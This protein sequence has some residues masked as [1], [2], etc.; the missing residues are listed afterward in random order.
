[1][2][3]GGLAPRDGGKDMTSRTLEGKN[4]FAGISRMAKSITMK[5]AA[6]F[7]PEKVIRSV[8]SNIKVGCI[9]VE[10]PDSGKWTLGH[11]ESSP[12][13]RVRVHRK[14]LFENLVQ[15]WDVGLGESYQLGDYDVDDLVA[16]IS[17]I[18]LNIPHL[19]GISGS[20]ALHSEVNREGGENLKIHRRNG[21]TLRGS[22]TNIAYHYD[23]SNGLYSLFLDPT[24]AYSCAVYEK[25]EDSL[26]RA[27]LNKFERLCR[28]LELKPGDHVL[29]IG[30]GWGGF[31]IY[32][33]GKYGCKVTTLT[34][35][36]EQKALA[37]ERIHVA[38]LESRIEVRLQDY[39]E[40]SGT[41]D[42]I[43][44]IE[45][46]EA[47]GY[48]YFDTFFAKCCEA[49]KPDGIM[50]MQVITMPDSR[51]DGYK[52][53]CD[54]IQKHIFPGS[55]LPSLYELARSVRNSGGLMIQHMENFDL[56]YARTLA[57]WRR[58]FHSSR[59]EVMALGFD[60]FFFRTWDYY[61]AYCEAAFRTRNI[62]LLQ[63]VL[64]RPNNVEFRGLNY[65]EG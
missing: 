21:N 11:P 8:M 10:S 14:A 58:A 27:Q 33:S 22:R 15:Y 57:D 36:A 48:E 28:K 5:S 55:L 1:M 13:C 32:A 61:L 45:M 54:W 23:L 51:F 50:A 52:D 64:T 26:H 44:S 43:V 60:E 42:K 2:F 24:M 25:P 30:S 53:G 4:R 3:S 49:L 18:I 29:E 7:F 63:L 46:F 19:P 6:L 17:I 41:Y 9:E 35:S 47:V 40:I 34:L 12:K 39:R 65:T 56:H 31:A 16:F 37:E 20:T 59:N 62:G 38:G